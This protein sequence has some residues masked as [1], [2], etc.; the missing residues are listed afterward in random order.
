MSSNFVVVLFDFHET[1]KTFQWFEWF[2]YKDGHSFP[3]LQC[4][5]G[6]QCCASYPRAVIWHLLND[7][8]HVPRTLDPW[9]AF[10]LPDIFTT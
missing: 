3:L 2:A 6:E 1:W 5:K 7:V 8:Q 9:E 10:N 4:R